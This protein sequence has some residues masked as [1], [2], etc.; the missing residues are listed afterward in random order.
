M[1]NRAMTSLPHNPNVAS[2]SQ[3][4]SAAILS[5]LRIKSRAKHSGSEMGQADGFL[6]GRLRLAQGEG[7]HRAGADAALLA[8]AAP[9]G[10]TGLLL[11][12][13]AGT[14]AVGLSAALLAPS[15]QVG[16][17]EIE[18]TALTLARRNIRPIISRRG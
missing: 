14:G 4:G 1:L 9:R 8:A 16:L 11:D 15:A 17:I 3:S 6:G 2:L 5:G 18:P 10:C 12:A 13:G 7:G